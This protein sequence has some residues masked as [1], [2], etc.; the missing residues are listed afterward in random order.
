[1]RL[2]AF[3]LLLPLAALGQTHY[4]MASGSW[5]NAA[6][7]SAGTVPTFAADVVLTGYTVTVHNQ[8]AVANSLQLTSGNLVFAG[9]A[10]LTLSN[11][12][13]IL[14]GATWSTGTRRVIGIIGTLTFSGGAISNSLIYLVG[15]DHVLSGGVFGANSFIEARNGTN[16]IVGQTVIGPTLNT[17]AGAAWRM[18]SST[19]RADG[20]QS[21]AGAFLLTN[22]AMTVG[23]QIAT[24]GTPSLE[25]V[26]S[27]LLLSTN[28][29]VGANGVAGTLSNL[30]VRNST[31][32]FPVGGNSARMVADV[33][34]ISSGTLILQAPAP[35]RTWTIN[36]PGGDLVTTNTGGGLQTFG[37][38]VECASLTMSSNGPANW[39]TGGYS[40]TVT[41]TA[42]TAG[43]LSMSNSTMF[44][45]DLLNSGVVSQ[46][47][48][49]VS[50]LAGDNIISNVP[51]LFTAVKYTAGTARI[52]TNLAVD[53]T[54]EFQSGAN[55]DGT[56]NIIG[57]AN[58]STIGGNLQSGTIT[59][60]V[61]RVD[62]IADQSSGQL[63][64][65][66]QGRR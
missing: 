47:T 29:N 49:T 51:T 27:T 24:S 63:N 10:G 22:S 46:Q 48:S 21:L 2:L 33:Y 9:N 58:P 41:G 66:R 32:R 52:T 30:T 42:R 50:L 14:G 17:A 39:A 40:L 13:S 60:N 57:L 64:T 38:A 45:R 62:G 28:L 26:D 34:A 37:A 61:L 12:A 3:L 53:G 31:I 65:P 44:V 43:T 7:W 6:I 23:Q 54:L 1:V 36:W 5:T 4:P 8:A 20:I 35:A 11:N 56:G 19:V 59:G 25:L 15:G 16:A 18:V 55:L